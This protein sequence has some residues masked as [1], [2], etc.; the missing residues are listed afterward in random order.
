MTVVPRAYNEMVDFITS[1]ISAQKIIA[2]KASNKLQK[3]VEELISKEKSGRIS[4]NEK[5]E[6]DHYMFLE[7]IMILA[8]AYAHKK[9]RT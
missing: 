3:R 7:H 5:S 2:F 9:L 8:K 4:D 1:E 6:L